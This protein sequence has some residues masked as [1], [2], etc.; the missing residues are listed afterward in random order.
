MDL[1][2]PDPSDP[3]LPDEDTLQAAQNILSGS[4]SGMQD[5]V[6][7]MAA[8]TQTSLGRLSNNLR[9]LQGQI[10]AMASTLDILSEEL[11]P[12]KFFRI[13]RSCILNLQAIESLVKHF[14]GRLKVIARPR[15]DFEM[16]VSRSR[17]EDFMLW[18]EGKI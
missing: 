9:T 3:E 4:L 16:T 5:Q 13:S 6:R 12:A 1:L 15:P 7:G 2:L 17:V 18:L 8:S 14:S 10:N 11:D